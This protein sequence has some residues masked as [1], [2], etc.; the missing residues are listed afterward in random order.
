MTNKAALVAVLQ[1]SVPSDSAD[2]VL[3]DAGIDGTATYSKD[4]ASAIDLAAI[5]VLQG[6]LSTPDVTEG[7]YS[8]HF[9]RNA[10]QA[11]LQYL[12]NKNGVSNPG[13]PV[14]KGVS[15]W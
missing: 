11:R 3:L 1:V 13:A 7:G 2:K 6:L 12:C 8:I 15:P 5:D 4:D 14:V 9:D 10:V